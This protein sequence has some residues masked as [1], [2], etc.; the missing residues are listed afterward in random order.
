MTLEGWMAPR[1]G[2]E[3]TTNGLTVRRSTAEL[4]GNTQALAKG[5]DCPGAG[6]TRQGI[7]TLRAAKACAARVWLIAGAREFVRR[8]RFPGLGFG[9]APAA[10][11]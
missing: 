2:I 11:I 7:R 4:P 10:A 6:R 5:A 3:P 8:R 1:V 9:A